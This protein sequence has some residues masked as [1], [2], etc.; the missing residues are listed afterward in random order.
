M[1]LILRLRWRGPFPYRTEI[2][3]PVIFYYTFQVG[4]FSAD[5]RG[6]LTMLVPR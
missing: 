3:L 1:D 4:S 2:T 6:F 5:I